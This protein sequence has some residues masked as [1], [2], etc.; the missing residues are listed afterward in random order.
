MISVN[1]LIW[2]TWLLLFVIFEGIALM[3]RDPGDTFTE[4]FRRWLRLR[5]PSVQTRRTQVEMWIGRVLVLLFGAWLTT[6]MAFGWFGGGEGFL[7]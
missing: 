2:A 5:T 6:H 1:G 7:G 3:D 4:H